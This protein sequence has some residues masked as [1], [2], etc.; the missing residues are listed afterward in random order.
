MFQGLLAAVA[1]ALAA[2]EVEDEAGGVVDAPAVLV[3]AAAEVAEAG[4]LHDWPFSQPHQLP[5]T[6]VKSIPQNKCECA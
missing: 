6:P 5:C 4:Y 2:A 1:A 3:A